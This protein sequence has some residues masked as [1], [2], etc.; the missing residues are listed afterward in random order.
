MSSKTDS[1]SAEQRFRDAFDRLKAD[2]PNA[3]PKGTPVTQNNVAK[4]A[5]CDQSALRKSRF[6]ALIRE[7]QA[8]VE[9]HHEN[10][11]SERQILLKRRKS[12]QDHKARLEEVL[13][14]RDVAQSKLVS[15]D[16][17]IV[18]LTAENRMLREQLEKAQPSA[19]T[20]QL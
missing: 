7:I 6:P 17:R 1:T 3:L 10:Q 5:G 18:E 15:A 8:Y 16:Q 14:Q 20:I 12:N 4:E 9:L 2:I 19:K 11:P 13:Q